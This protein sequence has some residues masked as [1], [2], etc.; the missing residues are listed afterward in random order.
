MMVDTRQPV[1]AVP[2]VIVVDDDA[3]VR[4]SLKFALEI[5]GFAVRIFA[6]GEDLM[7]DDAVTGSA[8]M[9]IDQKLPGTNGLDAIA[10]LRRR[11][12]TTPAILITSQPTRLVK[13]RAAQA[14]VPIVEKPLLGNSLIE[15]VRELTEQSAT[16]P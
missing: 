9:V 1:V 5:E 13:E 11:K 6:K 4:S 10:A 3:A 16:K 14:G 8:C 7:E 2:V 15:R 12:I